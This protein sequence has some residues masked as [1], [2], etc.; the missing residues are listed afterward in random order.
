MATTD[1][2]SAKQLK[3]LFLAEKCI[4]YGCY[5]LIFLLPVSK[6]AIEVFTCFI[7]LGFTLKKIVNP[8]FDF[9]KAHAA[10]FTILSSLV[11]FSALSLVNSG[12]FFSHS[13]RVLF[14][15]WGEYFL[16]FI[17]AID[18]FNDEKKIKKFLYVFV[19]SGF[20]VGLS[21]LSQKL[22]NFEFLRN[23]SMYDAR[24]VTGPFDNRNSFG[25]YLVSF[26][27]L[28]ITM[29]FL[30]WRNKVVSVALFSMSILLTLALVF[31]FSRSAWVA[32]SVSF[33]LLVTVLRKKNILLLGILTFFIFFFVFP[34]FK[35]RIM[36]IFMDEAGGGR[37]IIWQSVMTMIQENPLLG[38]GLG[39][40]MMHFERYA[41]DMGSY[42]AHNCYLQIWA[43]SGIFSL[44]SFLSLSAFVVYKGIRLSLKKGVSDLDYF[45][46]ALTASIVGFLVGSFFDTQLYSLQLS[47]LFWVI[48]GV[49]VALQGILLK[50][51]SC[52]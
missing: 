35:Q 51:A 8:N 32:F 2:Y 20:I 50:N 11:F 16:L 46:T 38:K 37:Y 15:K 42:Y 13:L 36:S 33:F 1:V 3:L 21:T 17:I 52:K 31:T 45:S 14:S 5:G 34:D 27:P 44:V 4:E 40:F 24:W 41:P 28:I 19:L 9:V 48:L 12:P 6:A 22:F 29:T 7:V 43:E 39:T 23:R 30:K 47:V 49:A 25:S 26:I 10:V 18:H